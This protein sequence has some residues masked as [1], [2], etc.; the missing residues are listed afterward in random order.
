MIRYQFQGDVHVVRG[1]GAIPYLKFM[2]AIIVVLVVNLT[3]RADDEANY[4]KA[5]QQAEAFRTHMNQFGC[6]CKAADTSYV[7]K[8]GET[9]TITKEQHLTSICTSCNSGT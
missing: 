4:Q 9:V 1:T 5:L 8:P 2:S 3:V 7:P 6:D